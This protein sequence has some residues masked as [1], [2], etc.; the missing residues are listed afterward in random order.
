MYKETRLELTNG[1]MAHFVVESVPGGDM[2]ELNADAASA[3]THTFTSIGPHKVKGKDNPPEIRYPSR[4]L[5]K[6]QTYIKT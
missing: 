5:T 6:R 4:Y 2:M 1:K 3:A